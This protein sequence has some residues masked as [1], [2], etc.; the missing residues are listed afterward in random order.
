[1]ELLAAP[2][3]MIAESPDLKI[4]L[5]IVGPA[6]EVARNRV[7]GAKLWELGAEAASFMCP[8]DRSL[9]A[10]PIG[11]H[12]ELTIEYTG[13]PTIVLDGTLA[14]LMDVAKRAVTIEMNFVDSLR[15]FEGKAQVPKLVER[16]RERGLVR[17][18]ARGTA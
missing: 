18:M 5:S 4:A 1:M 11:Q 15:G 13:E 10:L 2:R 8:W 16:L 9:L 12:L 14:Q 6:P 17:P 7:A 3:V